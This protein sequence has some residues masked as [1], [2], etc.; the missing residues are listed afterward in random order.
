MTRRL[1]KTGLLV[2]LAAACVGGGVALANH[3]GGGGWHGPQRMK[4]RVSERIDDALDAA[5]ATPAQKTAVYAARDHVFATF[6]EGRGDHHAQMEKALSL[7][8]QDKVDPAQI[9]ALRAEHEARAQRIGDAVVQ[10]LYDVHDALTPAQRTLVVQWVREHK[11]AHAMGAGGHHRGAA[12][13]KAMVSN[14]IDEGLDAAHVTDGQRARLHEVRDRVFATVEAAHDEDPSARIEQALALFQKD[15]LDA[16]QVNA[17]RAEH[18]AQGKK[19]G[20]ALV[21][22]VTEVHEVLTA[23]QRQALADWIRAQGPMTHEGHQAH[24]G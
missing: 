13:F 15:K 24:G 18:M 14:R 21:A 7:F 10:A 23:P 17:L 6:E 2:A 3:G 20:D 9:A 12:F 8:V 22:A 11:P 1:L 16:A 19:V 5:R 4:A